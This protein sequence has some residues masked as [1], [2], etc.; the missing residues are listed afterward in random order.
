LKAL[1]GHIGVHFPLFLY[2]FDQQ[3]VTLS[4]Q[5]A[6]AGADHFHGQIL[7]RPVNVDLR[8][9][10]FDRSY[11][12]RGAHLARRIERLPH[13]DV[14]VEQVDGRRDHNLAQLFRELVQ[15]AGVKEARVAHAHAVDVDAD[16]GQCLRANL[17]NPAFQPFRRSFGPGHVR[18]AFGSQTHS[19]L[20]GE[21]LLFGGQGAAGRRQ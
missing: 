17:A 6:V 4:P 7:A 1:A 18:V 13:A 19:L 10:R 2:L 21:H 12:Q 9:F 20:D 14:V 16:V 8:P 11:A 15:A 3:L 5:Q